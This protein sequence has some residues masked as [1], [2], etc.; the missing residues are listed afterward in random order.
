M[1]AWGPA[2]SLLLVWTLP[3]RGAPVLESAV[4]PSRP[5]VQEQIR[6]RVRLYRD[7]PLQRGHLLKPEIAD[8]LVFE[9]DEESDPQPV[10]RD[11]KRMERI[12]RTWLLFPQRSGLYRLPAPVFSGRDFYLRGRPRRLDVRP[13]PSGIGNFPW[14]VT[15]RLEMEEE[16]SA[17][18]LG[19]RPGEFRIR[20]IHLRALAQTGAQLPAPRMSPLPG[21]EIQPLPGKISN[22][23]EAGR[24]WGERFLA[25][26]YLATR[27]AKGE[28]PPVEVRWWDP[29]AEKVR[30]KRLPPRAYRIVKGATVA[31][32]PSDVGGEEE[33]AAAN[34]EAR[35]W[36]PAAW[37]VVVMGVAL[38]L[39]LALAAWR[40]R[41]RPRPLLGW[42]R[43]QLRLWRAC[44]RRDCRE[45]ARVI[46]SW[47]LRQGGAVPQQTWAAWR[48]L[49][50]ACFGQ[51]G[52]W[53]GRREWFSLSRLLIP[54]SRRKARGDEGSSLPPLWPRQRAAASFS[55]AEEVSGPLEGRSSAEGSGSWK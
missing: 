34:F 55:S 44:R 45:A 9:A 10:M 7:S 25:F 29:R 14:L 21:F 15:P 18:L 23:L 30:M 20:R 46:L 41:A 37:K 13:P 24:L 33:R 36:R 17:P 32:P 50:R 38:L 11:G 51:E 5:W 39:L 22:R 26:R 52:G 48:R 31:S 19:L 3:L 6:Y 49:D 2:L 28:V 12:E 40:R 4:E 8:M 43:A 47:R 35:S 1:K 42:V 53:G 54:P 27:P 16:W